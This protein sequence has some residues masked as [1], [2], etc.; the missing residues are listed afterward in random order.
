M[1]TNKPHL[2]TLIMFAKYSD[3]MDAEEIAKVADKIGTVSREDYLAIRDQWKQ[4]YKALSKKLHDL[5][6]Q[7][8]GGTPESVKAIEGCARGRDEARAYMLV[9][10]GL[11]EAARRDFAAKAA[12]KAA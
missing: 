10:H 1:E 8:K 11:K 12:F 7:R 6:P 9:R 3:P 5:K 2:A 4:E